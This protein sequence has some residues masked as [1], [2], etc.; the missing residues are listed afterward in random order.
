MEEVSKKKSRIT[1]IIIEKKIPDLV[2][3]I[4]TVTTQPMENHL[5]SIFILII[6]ARFL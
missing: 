5:C 6:A 3:L 2:G 4:I 1:T